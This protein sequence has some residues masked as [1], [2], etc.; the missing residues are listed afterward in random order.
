MGWSKDARH[1]SGRRRSGLG[2]RR[3]DHLDS[4]GRWYRHIEGVSMLLLRCFSAVGEE[5]A[6][7]ENGEVTGNDLVDNMAP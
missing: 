3:G 2:R 5:E 4:L 7:V 1:E 6:F